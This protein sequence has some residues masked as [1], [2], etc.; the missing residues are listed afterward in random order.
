MQA[1]KTPK[2]QE[3]PFQFSLHVR[4][5]SVD[6]AE[7]SRELQLTAVESFKAGAPRAS[8][9]G[10]AATAVHVE[11]YWAAVIDPVTWSLPALV[12]V[13]RER[14]VSQEGRSAA[15]ALP[16]DRH[17]RLKA[18]ITL[19][20]DQGFLSRDQVKEYLPPRML[21]GAQLAEVVDTLKDMG[22]A[23]AESSSAVSSMILSSFTPQEAKVLRMRFGIEGGAEG[24]FTL[25]WALWLT[26]A[27][28][29][30]RHGAYLKQLSA[31]GG[32]LTLLVAYSPRALAGFRLM[33]D[34]ARQI[35]DL[36]LTI[37]FELLESSQLN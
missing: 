22:I 30:S 21:P 6:P 23:V 36:G 15:D 3:L 18:L 1:R 34:T 5:P 7:V 35:G 26:C 24:P 2:P 14:T 31:Q 25:G 19:G 13:A 29:Y 4:H 28:L 33:P 32:S 16:L 17:T 8:R 20:R 12:P 27:C 9:S 10:I 37:K 11:T